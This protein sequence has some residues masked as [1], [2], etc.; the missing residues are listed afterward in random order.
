MAAAAAT[1]VAVTWQR[2]RFGDRD[3]SG[4]ISISL[5]CHGV[6]SVAGTWG[7]CAEEQASCWWRRSIGRWKELFEVVVVRIV[8]RDD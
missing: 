1:A 2:S 4:G 3:A 6:C 7:H 8:D 5:T